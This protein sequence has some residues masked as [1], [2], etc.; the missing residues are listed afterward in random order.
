MNLPPLVVALKEPTLQRVLHHDWTRKHFARLPERPD[1]EELLGASYVHHGTGLEYVMR[2]REGLEGAVVAARRASPRP[3]DRR[4]VLWHG[5]DRL[6]EETFYGW[7]GARVQ[8]LKGDSFRVL[9]DRMEHFLVADP[10]SG[11]VFVL[12]FRSFAALGTSHG[13]LESI[14]DAKVVVAT[15]GLY[16]RGGHLPSL[17]VY[18]DYDGARYGEGGRKLF[19]NARGAPV[20]VESVAREVL[21]RLG[22]DAV[23][24]GV[25][26]RLFEA[27]VGRPASHFSSSVWPT[28]FLN[29]RVS[30][31]EWVARGRRKIEEARTS[32]V[33]DALLAALDEVGRRPFHRLHPP[34]EGSL[35]YIGRYLSRTR[36]ESLIAAMGD[37]RVLAVFAGLLQG[38]DATASDWF[39]WQPQG[40]RAFFCEIKSSGDHL[41]ETQKETILWC[42]RSGAVDYR[43]L[44]VLHGTGRTATAAAAPLAPAKP[45]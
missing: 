32:G 19:Y 11:P 17:R 10:A 31:L 41:R 35:P 9:L 4:M 22:Y 33:G 45:L 44:E 8:R 23:H 38:H 13:V 43:L 20:V 25:F 3:G 5:K 24:P 27:L 6:V 29:G 42:Q 14:L 34:P 30:P 28:A 16:S 12:P 36:F 1:L 18:V 26:R 2:S 7:F 40:D 15:D 21:A 39:A 37:R